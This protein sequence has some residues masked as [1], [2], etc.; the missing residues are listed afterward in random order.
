V[1]IIWRLLDEQAG[2]QAV[3][4]ELKRI[5]DEVIGMDADTNDRAAELLTAWWYYRFIFPVEF[6]AGS[7][8]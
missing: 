2:E 5:C 1:P 7:D 3:S 6:A 4:A 8:E